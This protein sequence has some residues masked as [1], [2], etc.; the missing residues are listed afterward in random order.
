[1]TLFANIVTLRGFL[2]SDARVPASDGIS[3]NAFAVLT[4]CIESGT[5]NKAANE[6]RPSTAWHRIICPGPFFCGFT[7][8]MKQGD[9]V[10]IEG[11]LH[12]S[13]YDR[14]I[15]IAGKT[16]TDQRPLYEVHATQIRKLDY[17]PVGVDEGE[18]D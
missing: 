15:V 4:L 14:P 12:V 1:M 9:Y 11:Q 17:P 13:H 7:R 18:D 2:G 16:V 5:W 3:R 6:W 10:E 8:G